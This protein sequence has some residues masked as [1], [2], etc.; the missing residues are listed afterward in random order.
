M[1][2]DLFSLM[3]LRGDTLSE[4][5]KEFGHKKDNSS[6]TIVDR[7]KKQI[8]RDKIIVYQ[9]KKIANQPYNYAKLLILPGITGDQMSDGP[10]YVSNGQRAVFYSRWDKGGKTF[11]DD[12]C[13]A[14]YSEFYFRAQIHDIIVIEAIETH[15]LA[16]FMGMF[17]LEIWII[18]SIVFTESRK[19]P[20]HFI[21]KCRSFNGIFV[22][23]GHSSYQIWISRYPEGGQFQVL[24]IIKNKIFSIFLF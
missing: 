17:F 9:A 10:F 19:N 13:L 18:T 8:K 5:C 20:H 24:F 4:I 14:I 15:Q 11:L 6:G 1:F 21:V 3:S 7:V 12:M 2:L 22:N 23:M 16:E